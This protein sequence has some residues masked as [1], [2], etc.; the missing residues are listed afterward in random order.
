MHNPH[1]PCK[2]LSQHFLHAPDAI[3]RILYAIQPVA[4]QHVVEIGPGLGAITAPLLAAVG[5]LE[6]VELDRD[7]IPALQRRCQGLGELHIHQAD[8]LRFD[9]A[10]L[11]QDQQLRVVGNLPYHI[12]TPLLFH[13][14]NQA[15]HIRDMHFMLQKEVVE[16]MAASPCQA[17]YGRLSVMLQYYCRVEPLF[18]LGRGAFSPP[19]R[20]ESAFVRL[21]P[22]AQP[23]VMVRDEQSFTDLVRQAFSQR[24]KMLRNTLSGLLGV[25]DIEAAGVDPG[26]R[27]ETLSLADFAALSNRLES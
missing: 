24:R 18:A 23:P 25:A 27:P 14:L 1:R 19:P 11:R 3:R 22:Y 16:R 15:E 21:T 9:F 8:A 12:S 5:Y 4:G 7:L 26:A 2:R 20:V 6:V 13:L 17:A 10:S